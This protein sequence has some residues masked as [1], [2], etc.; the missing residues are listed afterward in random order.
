MYCSL[1]SV[2]C[3]NSGIV[4]GGDVA[5]HSM[6]FHIFDNDIPSV[7]VT[8]KDNMLYFFI[9]FPITSAYYGHHHHTPRPENTLTTQ[10]LLR[11]ERSLRLKHSAL[12][13]Q[14]IL[15]QSHS[16]QQ[17][18]QQGGETMN[19]NPDVL[20]A[21]V[22]PKPGERTNATITEIK[23]GKLGEFVDKDVLSTWKNA[24][25]ESPVIEISASIGDSMTRKKIIHVP[26]SGQVHPLSNLAK[27]KKTYGDYPRQGQQV[28][29]VADE[30]GFYQFV[31]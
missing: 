9:F 16:Q 1:A 22:M 24:D 15:Q 12:C 10:K 26:P 23:T 20:Q 21:K 3:D 29:L 27:W 5:V 14:A 28:F 19:Y 18:E 7:Y 13:A 17:R 30:E 25:P 6:F 2:W 4:L 31:V 8:F 11:R